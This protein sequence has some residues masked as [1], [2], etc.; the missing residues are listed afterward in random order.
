M[1]SNELER[2]LTFGFEEFFMTN[3]TPRQIQKYM[4]EY[5]K[6]LKVKEEN[7]LKDAFLMGWSYRGQ[8]DRP[9]VLADLFIETRHRRKKS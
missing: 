2:Y 9:E 5:V 6:E 1:I 3:L 4:T 7:N 8:C